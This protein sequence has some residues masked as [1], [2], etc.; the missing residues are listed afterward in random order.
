MRTKVAVE[1][2]MHTRTFAALIIILAALAC[3]EKV[4]ETVVSSTSASTTSTTSAPGQSEVV[5]IQGR[6]EVLAPMKLPIL[7]DDSALGTGSSPT[8]GVAEKKDTFAKSDGIKATLRTRK[9]PAGM[10][11]RVAWLD[12]QKKILKE[13]QKPIPGEM[14]WIVFDAPPMKWGT[15]VVEMYLGGNLVE[16]RPFRVR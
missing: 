9:V 2:T 16:T 6:T 12:E 5:S 4:T 3:R 10:V 15:Y 11:A 13:E 7:L 14:V 1:K 8:E